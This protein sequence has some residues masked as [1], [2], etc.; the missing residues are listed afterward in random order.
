[1]AGTIS[2][3]PISPFW[4]SKATCLVGSGQWFCYESGSGFC[5]SFLCLT[6]LPTQCPMSVSELHLMGPGHE[7]GALPF[8]AQSVTFSLTVSKWIR[9]LP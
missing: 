1:M 3:A 4:G 9:L 8:L 6:P 2:P 7:S 5:V